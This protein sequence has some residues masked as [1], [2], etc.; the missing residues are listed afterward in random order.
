M[1]DLKAPRAF[2]VIA[3]RGSASARDSTFRLDWLIMLDDTY[4]DPVKARKI[5]HGCMTS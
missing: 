5:G 1:I 4:L 3:Q 2:K